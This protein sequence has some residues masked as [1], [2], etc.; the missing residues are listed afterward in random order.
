MFRSTNMQFDSAA[1]CMYILFLKSISLLSFLKISTIIHHP[2]DVFYC[3][4]HLD[5]MKLNISEHL[6]CKPF[7]FLCVTIYFKPSGG[8]LCQRLDTPMSTALRGN[9]RLSPPLPVFYFYLKEM[10]TKHGRLKRP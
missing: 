1:I 2:D 4:S 5:Q 9:N 7:K 6:H 3:V 10:Q 8:L